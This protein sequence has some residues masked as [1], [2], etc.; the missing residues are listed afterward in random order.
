MVYDHFVRAE[1]Y[2]YVTMVKNQ[3]QAE[4]TMKR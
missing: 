4:K 1:Q 2:K 3:F